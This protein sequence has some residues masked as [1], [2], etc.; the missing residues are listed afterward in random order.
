MSLERLFLWALKVKADI[1]S[2]GKNYFCRIF[3][4]VLGRKKNKFYNVILLPELFL[5]VY[6]AGAEHTPLYLRRNS[7]IMMSQHKQFQIETFR[8]SLYFP[9][10]QMFWNKHWQCLFIKV[11]D[12]WVFQQHALALNRLCCNYFSLMI[13]NYKLKIT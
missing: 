12:F 9:C 1:L 3:G 6:L 5:S 10:S 7:Q 2:Y 11:Q 4:S 13:Q 8:E